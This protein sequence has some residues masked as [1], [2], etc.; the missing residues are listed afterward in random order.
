MESGG[1]E[2]GDMT[3]YTSREE[4]HVAA[5]EGIK[6]SQLKKLVR[7]SHCMTNDIMAM[8]SRRPFSMEWTTGTM[9]AA[10]LSCMLSLATNPACVMH[11]ST[12]VQRSMPGTMQDSQHCS[13]QLSRLNHNA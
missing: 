5:M 6:S 12:W 3:E 11:F 4:I 13:G 1:G 8:F 10:H 9:V 7:P 2:L